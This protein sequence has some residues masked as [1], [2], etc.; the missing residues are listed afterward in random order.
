VR[1]RQGDYGDETVYGDDPVA[2]AVAFAAAGAGWI[3]V[4]DLDAA[5]T[6]EAV[7]HDAIVTMVAAVAPHTRLQVGGGVRSIDDVAG[8]LEHGVARVVMGTAAVEQPAEVAEAA[9]RWPG[10]VAVGVDHRDGVVRVRGWNHHTGVDLADAVAAAEA[11]GAA[12]VIVT[13]I[14]VDGMLTGPP[15]EQ[16]RSVLDSTALPVI[17]SG[18]VGSVDDLHALARLRSGHRSLAGVIVGTALYEGRFGVADALAACRAGVA[19]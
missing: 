18:G 7:N 4:V 3:H 11:N 15:L 9:R 6:G 13:D 19:P 5:R 12:A 2:R 16:L 17:A 14:A 8:L 10:R 1:L